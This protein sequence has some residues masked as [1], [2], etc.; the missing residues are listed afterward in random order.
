MGTVYEVADRLSGQRIALKQVNA[1]ALALEP[2]RADEIALKL[3]Q[4]FQTLASL[5]H[6]N[7]I[8]VLDYGFDT[9]EDGKRQIYYTMELLDDSRS[10]LQ[11]GQGKSLAEQVD[12]LVG[13]LQALTYLHRRGILHRDLKP[14]NIL[15]TADGG[16][17][18]LDFGLSIL[19]E[20]SK[21]SSEFSGTPAYSAPELFRGASA[22]EMS[23]L[24][25]VGVIAYELLT[26]RYPFNQ[27]SF[28]GMLQ[29]ILNDYPDFASLY[30][31][32]PPADWLIEN[33][34]SIAEIVSR[35]MAKA[36]LERYQTA[37]E[38]ISDLC[39][40][41]GRPL[42]GESDN[43]RESFL[44]AA[45]FIGREVEFKQLNSALGDALQ[46][47]GSAWLVTGESGIGK[48]RLLNE[49]RTLGLIQQARVLRGQAVEGGGRLYQLWRDPLRRLALTTALSD[50]DASI[51]K[52]IVPDISTL[53]GREIA[54]VPALDS[55]DAQ[56]R[57][58]RTIVNV[59]R[60]QSQPILLLLEDLQ[61]ANESLDVLNQLL[62]LVKNL[63][64]LLVGSSRYDELLDLPK[65]L[66]LMQVIALQR[67][68]M[69]E[70]TDLS[71]SM[72]GAAGE[73]P[74]VTGL[75]QRETEGN[76][77]FIVE[78]VRTLAEEA[79]SLDLI[80][81]RTLPE[82]VFAGGMQSILRRRLACVPENAHALLQRAAVAGRILDLKVLRQLAGFS[83]AN[84]LDIWL[85]KCANAAVLEVHEDEWRFSH[86]KLR[87][88]LIHEA[89]TSG[90][91][92]A[93]N[94][95]VALAIEAAY[96]DEAERSS[97]A[98]ALADHWHAAGDIQREAYYVARAGKL[99]L[100]SGIYQ[101]AIGYFERALE[102][103]R[104][105]E[106][107]AF[108]RAT[109]LSLLGEACYSVGSLEQGYTY[110]TTALTT[111]GYT[112]L[113]SRR[114][115]QIDAA[116]QI[117]RQVIYQ[118]LPPE[119]LASSESQALAMR[120]LA[121]M[122]QL[123]YFRNER[124]ETTYFSLLG[125]NIAASAGDDALTE[126]VRI[127]AGMALTLALVTRRTLA[128]RYD[129][130]VESLIGRITDENALTW[131]L[132]L[133]GIYATITSS[134][135]EAETQLERCL[136]IARRIGH[137][138]RWEEGAV[139]LIGVY[140]YRGDWERSR[141]LSDALYA[142]SQQ[143][144]NLQA[145][146]W[147]LDDLGRFELRAG[148]LDEAA[149]FFRRSRVIYEGINDT[150]GLIWIF[151]ATAK[152]HLCRGE[153][154]HVLPLIEPVEAAL[155]QSVPT[156]FGML[157]AYGAVIEYRLTMLER[158]PQNVIY[159]RDALTVLH[160]LEQYA[161]I[162]VLATARYC[163]YQ[164]WL[165]RINGKWAEAKKLALRSLQEARRIKMA[166][167]EGLA[168]DAC[169]RLPNIDAAERR[170][171]LHSAARIFEQLGAHWDLEQ[172]K[173]ALETP[174]STAKTEI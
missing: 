138:R 19:R 50:L 1:D 141:A 31:L 131:I 154:E 64:L 28:N 162:F 118:F 132:V 105:I 120:L 15:I 51:L 133:R 29:S 112:V 107:T 172:T 79:G 164:S 34:P 151:G 5:R 25:T 117:L 89:A 158:D 111:L 170:V 174:G 80:G 114:Q 20:Q 83:R 92:P 93:L 76:V 43:I 159:R 168:S 30:A 169:G 77:F 2:D 32:T 109:L 67:L 62:P 69:D 70:I 23:D 36:P 71:R 49:L 3:A 142:S 102:L 60:A 173:H 87:E 125:L 38:I 11:A 144:G 95:E 113:D 171:H 75:I 55:S 136:E 104:Q 84:A 16:V 10:I 122:V 9:D 152:I 48:S 54:D 153:I 85:V 44:Q 150:I 45:E 148:N 99:A 167:E 27:S 66:T 22:S 163:L 98:Q 149:D 68:S 17:K 18:V 14:E 147:A 161:H 86:D 65:R 119:Q 21:P 116:R 121:Q 41:T 78:V 143:S 46:G 100:E 35:M 12:L 130:R 135:A 52:E 127:H 140:Y 81:S 139:T 59:F 24:Y 53:L 94:R 47:Y 146:A 160:Y 82:K 134:W 129:Q 128:Q 13:L 57:L 72:L 145:Q 88:V 165:A 126:S 137:L 108:Q 42:P 115:R 8:S 39:A 26:G 58:L 40:A 74:D 157:E 96:P 37:A 33:A 56:Q 103:S 97:R 4:E 7:V 73:K 110:S 106:S 90:D 123:H 124:F 156:S 91:I 166:Y 6:P 155:A 63:P 61:W 101:R